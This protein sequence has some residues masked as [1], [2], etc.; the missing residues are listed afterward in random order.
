MKKVIPLLALLL[1][2]CQHK[3]KIKGYIVFKNYIERHTYREHH[4]QT[5][6]RWIIHVGNAKGTEIIDVDEDCYN[7]LAV[8]DKVIVSNNKVKLIK[9]GC[10]YGNN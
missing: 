7:A 5:P 4:E 9:K 1:F 3:Q 8:T 6:E 10:R 2:S